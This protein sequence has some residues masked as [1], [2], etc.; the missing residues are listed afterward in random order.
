[1]P[2]MTCM[3]SV[4]LNVKVHRLNHLRHSC[5]ISLLVPCAGS[6]VVRIDPLCFLAGCHK[7]QLNQ[8]L[9]IISLSVRFF[10]VLLFIRAAFV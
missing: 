1:M 9:F 5:I 10:S 6:G 2:P 7:R 3:G 8:A 4:E